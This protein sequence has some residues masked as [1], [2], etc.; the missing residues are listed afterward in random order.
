MEELDGCF[1]ESAD[2]VPRKDETWSDTNLVGDF[3]NL[4]EWRKRDPIIFTR[5]KC[6]NCGGLNFEVLVT[7]EY[8]TSARCV[9]CG[10][11]YIVH[12]G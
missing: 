12:C 1:N 4:P 11:Y 2:K 7:D 3:Q 10:M 6:R 9:N 5:L 8:E